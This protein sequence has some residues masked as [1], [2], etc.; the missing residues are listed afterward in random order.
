MDTDPDYLLQQEL[1]ALAGNAYTAPSNNGAEPIST[2]LTRW[3]HLFALSP[4]EAIARLQAHRNNLTRPRISAA[5]WEMLRAEKE[6]A[7]YDREAYEYELELQR[8][9]AALPD[10]VP[11]AEG[12]GVTY[13]VELTG[14]LETAEEVRQAA[15][16]AEMPDVVRGAW[17]QCGGAAAGGAVLY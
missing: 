1:E 8:R 17:E 2:T 10:A 11:S 16:M 15:G 13:L 6:A 5:H 14:S 12:S 3:Q 4:N 7:G 9:K